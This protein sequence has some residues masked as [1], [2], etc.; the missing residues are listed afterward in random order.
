MRIG[1]IAS[2]MDTESIVRQLMQVERQPLDR[3]FQQKQTLEW[4][5][6][7]YREMNLKLRSLEQ[8]ASSIRLRA[9]LNTRQATSTVPQ[10]FTATANASVQAGEYKFKVEQVATRTRN[11]S[12]QS[13]ISEGK[14]LSTTTRLDQQ[15][16]A[17]PGISDQHGATFSIKTFDS[18]GNE[19]TVTVEIDTTKSIN[20]NLKQITDSDI[21]VRAY[22][23]SAFN[24]VV[25]ERKETG[26]FLDKEQTPS[27]Q[28]IFDDPDNFLRDV[29]KI[30]QVNESSGKNAKVEFQNPLFGET[31]TRDSR[32]NRITI[33]G[34]TFN[35]T[36]PTNNEFKTV[37]VTSNTD[38]AFNKIKAFVDAYNETI[39][40]IQAQLN[41]PK[42]RGFPPLTDEQ[43][44]EL[45]E[46]EAEMW[47]EKAKSGLLRRD[48]TLSNVLT[49]MRND[50]YTP[51]Q[52]AGKFTQISQIGIT[53]TSNFRDGGR[54]EI[55][56]AKLRA[57]LEDDPDAV[58]SLLNNAANPDLTRIRVA[59]RTPEERRT[60]QSETGLIGRLRSTINASINQITSRAGNENRTNQQFTIGRE[61]TNI[62]TRMSAFERRLIDIENRHWAQ[63]TRME[64]VLN[65]SQAQGNALMS[66]LF[67]GM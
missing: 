16:V 29:F 28:M 22:F 7:A 15:E 50:L 59:D 60:I 67:G 64:R 20:D 46:R 25:F 54:L 31:I 8:S 21:G 61:L 58:H 43:R 14:T 48:P 39:A 42:H 40:E 41:E 45:T 57:A 33:G 30:E 23:D 34:I 6:D 63:F 38:D 36:Q 53:T 3:L 26:E 19:K 52:T 62:D 47:D 9:D 56:E 27:M 18:T 4:Q 32:S 44:R 55:D 35:V 37:N 2:G 1:G 66:Q 51:V 10:M 24:R 49:Q 65:E 17:I 5:R 13:I 12:Q 11:V